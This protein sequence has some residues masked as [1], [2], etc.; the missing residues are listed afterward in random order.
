MKRMPITKRQLKVGKDK[1]PVSNG[2]YLSLN[3]VKIAMK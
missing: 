2:V 3:T 1:G